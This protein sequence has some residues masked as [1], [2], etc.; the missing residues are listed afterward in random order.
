MDPIY[1]AAD[2]AIV[3]ASGKHKAYS[4]PGDGPTGHKNTKPIHVND[5][6]IFSDGPAPDSEARGSEWFTR[7]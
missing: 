2:R 4:L 6:I 5:G 7:A 1:C 3:A